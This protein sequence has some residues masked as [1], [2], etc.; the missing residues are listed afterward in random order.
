MRE[1]HEQ[2]LLF[3]AAWRVTRFSGDHRDRHTLDAELDRLLIKPMKL[4]PFPRNPSLVAKDPQ[5]CVGPVKMD[6]PREQ[7]RQYA[8]P[9]RNFHRRQRL[10]ERIFVDADEAL[11]DVV[12]GGPDAFGEC[13]RTG[14]VV[15]VLLLQLAA[16]RAKRGI[17]PFDRRKALEIDALAG[18]THRVEGA[19][20]LLLAADDIVRR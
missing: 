10:I 8:L 14:G 13:R 16:I 17:Q 2:V 15:G 20:H 3:D 9:L 11:A 18:S 4:Q 5:L 12:G 1:Q 6:Q 19:Y 7:L